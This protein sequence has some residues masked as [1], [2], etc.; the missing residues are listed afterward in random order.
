MK[1]QTEQQTKTVF[2]VIFAWQDEKEE[3][4]LEEMAA[5]GWHLQSV[6]PYVYYFHRG[7]P[8]GSVY[9]LDYKHTF[10]KDYAEYTNIFRDSGW[11]L[12]ATMANWHYYRIDPLNDQQPEIFNSSHAKAQK[13]RRLLTGLVPFLPIYII[14]LNPAKM[15]FNHDDSVI[16]TFEV[17]IGVLWT[18]II[19]LF[20]F[21]IIRLLIKIRKLES[22]NKE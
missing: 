17:A 15:L 10:D 19:I 2:K 11:E 16:S 14:L 21:A 9:R 8:R 13:Y 1:D 20:V 22:S 5:K 12:V 4:W 6:T 18:L 3:K 7:E